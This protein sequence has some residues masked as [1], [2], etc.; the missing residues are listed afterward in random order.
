MQNIIVEKPYKFVPPHRGNWWP[1]FIQLT[2]L[3]LRY[4]RR[5][6]GIV[7]YEVR[8]ADRLR[9]SLDAGHGIVL[10]PNHSRYADPLVI[11][12]LMR[13]IHSH[14]FVMTSWHLF[15]Q[16]WFT[17]FAIQKMGGFSVNRE[18][19][20]RQAINTAIEIVESAERP[21]VLFPEGAVT[22][23]NDRLHALLDGVAFIARTAAKRRK[24]H[25]GGKV[26]VHPV[27]IKYRFGG[28]LHAAVDD[29]LSEIEHRLSWR[30]Q[31]D[32][33]MLGR[34][35]KLGRSLL[36]LKELEYFGETQSG[37]LPERLQKLID[38]LLVP[39][40]QEWLG[41]A[42]AGPVVPRIKNLR[43]KILPDMVQG[44]L[45]ASERERRW[46][47]LADMY[48]AQQVS[49]YPPD[50]LAR[51]SS[52]RMLETV[53]RYEEDLTDKVRVHGSLKAIIDV[54]EV[55]EVSPERDRQA[56]IDPLMASIER[57]LQAMLDQLAAECPPYEEL[58]PAESA[59]SSGR[60]G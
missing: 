24:K 11:G 30:P 34:I 9:A 39:L 55:I 23:T 2:G 7:D 22:R 29:V 51:P 10:T 21:L 15:N 35:V 57:G 12:R 19:V 17:S 41:A 47:H 25:Q 28:D 46:Q 18:G 49:C 43:M 42:D 52:E 8:H 3:H 20:D 50:Y 48:L 13:E 27:A 58:G 6:E 1:T 56:R 45:D 14:V 37:S 4:L 53:E 16:D 54:G 44:R 33:P 59:R 5:A 60:N 36:C 32:L 26:V 40:E 38:R 31:R